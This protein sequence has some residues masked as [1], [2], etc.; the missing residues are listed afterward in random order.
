MPSD[1]GAWVYKLESVSF[2]RDERPVLKDVSFEVREGEKVVVL[3]VNGAGKTT[4]LK[5]LNGLIFPTGGKVFFRGR[6]LTERSLKDQS[7]KKIFRSSVSLMFQDVDAMFFNATVF[8][9]IAF[10]LRQLGLREEDVRERV[11]RIANI[12]N[13]EDILHRAPYDLSGGEKKRTAFACCIVH[14]P[15]V[16]LLD[17]PTSSLDPEG[18]ATVVELLA[19]YGGTVI[20]ATHNLSLAFELGD[21]FVVLSKEHELLFDGRINSLRECVDILKEAGL[22]HRHKHRHGRVIHEHLHL[23]DWD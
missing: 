16:L 11:K 1:Q 5:V 20:T 22:V 9:E 14:E 8:D 4:L 15:E 18:V 23:H 12:L 6:E 19:D 3:G 17:E 10:S 2:L 7:F 13:L 21:R